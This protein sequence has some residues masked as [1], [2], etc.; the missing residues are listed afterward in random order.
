MKTVG[1]NHLLLASLQ[2][3]PGV[4]LHQGSAFPAWERQYFHGITD[5]F[6][7]CSKPSPHC[8]PVARCPNTPAS[9]NCT[10]NQ[11]SNSESPCAPPHLFNWQLPLPKLFAGQALTRASEGGSRTSLSAKSISQH[12]TS[13]ILLCLQPS[14]NQ[15]L[16][17]IPFLWQ[18]TR[19]RVQQMGQVLL[20]GI[21]GMLL[22]DNR[23]KHTS[24]ITSPHTASPNGPQ[25]RFIL[26]VGHPGPLSSALQSQLQK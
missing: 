13:N 25:G 4:P 21:K 20:I 18:F 9:A 15:L 5:G 12:C 26:P 19:T 7:A 1:C 8:Q 3:A 24:C 22:A 16:P 14:C 2:P 6:P 10:H 17:H 23:C 11:L